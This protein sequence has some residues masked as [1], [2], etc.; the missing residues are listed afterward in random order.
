MSHLSSAWSLT[1]RS[2]D[3]HRHILLQ[4]KLHANK[5]MQEKG[6]ASLGQHIMIEAGGI[7][8]TKKHRVLRSLVLESEGLKLKP[9]SAIYQLHHCSELL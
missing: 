7:W 2:T 5:T 6:E 4:E 1:L 8:E 3:H 9:S